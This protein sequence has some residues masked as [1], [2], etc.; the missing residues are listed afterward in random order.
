MH[1]YKYYNHVG[2]NEC[3]FRL[4]SNYNFS[5]HSANMCV[6]SDSFPHIW[7]VFEWGYLLISSNFD[8]VMVSRALVSE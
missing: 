4:L 7:R 2:N 1:M 8:D 6:C 3:D 5:S